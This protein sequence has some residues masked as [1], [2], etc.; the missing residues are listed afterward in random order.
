VIVCVVLGLA[1]VVCGQAPAAKAVPAKQ[2]VAVRVDAAIEL[3]GRLTE[4]AWQ[5][6]VPVTDFIQ[7]EP[8]EG[9]VP[10]ERM[11]VRFLYD[12]GAL[13][14]GAR[15]HSRQPSAIQAPM[16]RR[17]RGE[18]AEH[19]LVSFDTFLDHRTAY[20]FGVTAS[21]VR[22]DRFYPAD[23]AAE[24]IDGYDPVWE[25]RAAIDETGWTAEL[26]I[27]LS[28]LRF[29]DRPEQIWGVNIQRFTPTLNEEDY[30]ILVP[31]TEKGWASH[32]GELRGIRDLGTVRR[33]ELV[34]YVAGTSI[35][36]Q[37]RD[38]SNPFQSA[39]QLA[40]Q[41][42]ADLKVGIGP[43]LTLDVTMN[44]DFGQ[45]EADPAEVNLSA[46]QT[47]FAEKRPFFT[48][49]AQLLT[50]AHQN[51]FYSRRIGA[52]PSGPAAGEYVNYP[53]AS[54]ILAAGKLT[55]RLRSGTSV[56]MLSAV[57]DEELADVSSLASP[58]IASVRV[59]ARTLYSVARVQQ[60]F[61]PSGS[62]A[63]VM[64]AGVRRDLKTGDPLAAL[65]PRSTFLA[66]GDA[67]LRL[68]GGAYEVAISGAGTLVGGDASAIERVQRS[69]SHYMQRPD[70]DHS[71]LDPT[72]TTLGGYSVIT[73]VRRVSGRH[74]LWNVNTK[75]DSR[76]FESNDIAILN[77]ADSVT[78]TVEVRYRETRPTRI[79]RSYS[80]GLRQSTEW[81][82]GGE[83]GRTP[84]VPSAN[85]TWKN[86]WTT[87][88]SL[89]NNLRASNVSL[90]RGGPAMGTPRGW[91]LDATLGSSTAVRTRWSGR[92]TVG[93]DENSGTTRRLNAS[94]SL[95]PGPRWELSITPAFE[96]LVDTQQYV[97]T[98][99]AGRAATYGNRY[100][101][102][103]ID[104]RTF[105]SQYRLN[106]TLRPDVNLDV[107]AE[108]FASSG[109]YFDHGELL[110][111][112]S[113]QLL[114]YGSSD[115]L[116]VVQPDGSRAIATPE[117]GFTLSNADF[118]VR[119]FRSNVVLRWEWRPGST[120]YFVW[121]QDRNGTDVTGAPVRLGDMFRSVTSPGPNYFVL[122]TS[123]WLPF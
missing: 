22:L 63:S 17:D 27:P 117:G 40:A 58:G 96:H 82:Y 18:Q 69:S 80:I 28:Q 122:K 104:R 116:A 78:P 65:L 102:A 66:G 90:T 36:N 39:Q 101:F 33:L 13:Y 93:S 31:R 105:S 77:S 99:G 64:A 55:G 14:V 53:S 109:R 44:P 11:D 123:F 108:P 68:K 115:T 59:A 107:Y 35:V 88:V 34:P 100:V 42:G 60:E 49:G 20:A 24:F 121:Q 114:R 70:Q 61:G 81:T 85:L 32:F 110:A 112:G 62:T 56:G 45:V 12:E 84:L 72:R 10:T 15:M 29:T 43:N 76:G 41:G 9:A 75:A 94:V 1:R 8:V 30:W 79:F 74:W 83:R 16:G 23:D 119:S 98:L 3:D 5:R 26:W 97:G 120:L 103:H 111:P 106:F 21:G 71:P 48:E 50:I 57:T 4:E 19:I 7:K 86:F 89:A 46:F 118:N 67:L 2:A 87:S 37:S 113:R 52:R 95:R 47:R 38:R 6:A 91:I 25:A 92:A 54:T 73:A 51:V